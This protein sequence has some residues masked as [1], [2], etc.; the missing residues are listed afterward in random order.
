MS[1]KYETIAKAVRIELDKK[2]DDI[3]IVFKIIDEGFKKK[4]RED[5]LSDYEL[6]I[7]DKNLV[8]RR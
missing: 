5:W 8:E 3:Y 7:V 1:A 6:M 2:N 4:V